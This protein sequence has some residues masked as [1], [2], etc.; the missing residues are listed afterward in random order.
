MEADVSDG[1]PVFE[2]VGFLAS[3]VKEARERVR[4]ALRNVGC[5][6]PPRRITVNFMPADIRKSGAGFDLPIAVA[7]LAAM[8]RLPH[9]VL[10]DVLIVGEIGLNGV[11]QPVHGVLPMV[12]E[13][14]ERGI[15]RCIVP[16]ANRKEAALVS[17]MLVCGVENIGEVMRLLEDASWEKYAAEEYNIEE[18]QPAVLPDFSEIHGQRLMKRACEVA[19]TGMHNLLFVGPPGAGKTMVAS[20]IPS[21]LPPLAE[22]ERMELS[23][24]Y[25]VKGMLSGENGLLTQRPFRAPHHTVSVQGLTGGGRIPQPGEISLAHKGV[26]FLDELPEFARETVEA[27]RQ[28][29]EEGAVHLVRLG[30][31]YVYPADFML[32]AAMNPCPC[33]YYPDMQKCRC[34]QTA[35][36]RYLE[37]ISQPILDRID[38]CVEAPALTFGQFRSAWRWHRTFNGSATGRKD[39]RT[40]ARYLPRRS[41]SIV[42]LIKS[43][44]SIW[45]RSTESC[46]LPPDLTISFCGWRARWRIWTAAVGFATGIWR[47]QSATEALTESSGRGEEMNY[48]YWFANI[49]GLSNCAKIS[50]HEKVGN[51]QDIYFLSEKQ[52]ENMQLLAKEIQAVRAAQKTD[53]EEAYA[54]M[55]E[56]GISFVSLEDASYPKRLRHIANPPYGLYVKGCL[57]QGETVAIVGARMCSEYGRTVA[58]EL[59]RMLA[60]RGVGVVSGMARGIDAAG[61]QGALD[62]GG[63]SCAV[64]GCGVDVCYPKSSRALYEEILERGSVVSEYPPGTQPIPGYFPQRNRIISGLV[65]AVVVVEAKQRSGSLITADF[66]LEQG[67]DVYA[68]PGRIT[69]ALSAG[70]NSLIRQGAGAVS[71]LESFVQELAPDPGAGGET[72]TFEK[73]LLEKEERLVYSCVD[74][75]PKSMEELLEETDLSVPE[76]AQILGILLKKG[77]V[78]EAFKNCYIRRI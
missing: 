32:V 21:I 56:S 11:V 35:I 57:P 28:P 38:I 37:R 49:P 73:L 65:R 78:T 16:R 55:C 62:V 18:T 40:T 25:S 36:H 46:S 64:L 17:G 31:S 26:L 72:C 69:D 30:G 13:A 9:A 71:D 76:L 33:G 12:A 27:L 22:A 63:I 75:R 48:A 8:G 68:I 42:L 44:S 4:T 61:H 53:M 74:L 7:V 5:A 47:R 23:K 2:M 1:M 14:K 58:R 20:R 43:R 41:G 6:L 59:G 50:I 70:C 3:E 51:A 45:K 66:A 54:K 15:R 60:A 39:F 24:I 67:R 10:D 34:T 19:V 77:F 52:M 29:L